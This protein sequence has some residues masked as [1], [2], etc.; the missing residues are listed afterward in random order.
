MSAAENGEHETMRKK[1]SGKYLSFD[2]YVYRM[3][4]AKDEFSL[5]SS[6]FNELSPLHYQALT[7]HSTPDF[8]FIHLL[9][10]CFVSGVHC[11]FT[12][13]TIFRGFFLS[14]FIYD[15]TIQFQTHHIIRFQY[16][17]AHWLWV[18]VW[19][20]MCRIGNCRNV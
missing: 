12:A 2:I 17:F 19:C 5:A 3:S 1:K 7:V 6:N 15:L 4:N 16:G 10:M 14:A 9:S 18:C 13:N 8:F 20:K 11:S